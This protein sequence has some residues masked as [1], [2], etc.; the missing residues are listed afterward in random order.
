M[1]YGVWGL[2]SGE[3]GLGLGDRGTAGRR[4]GPG[5]AKFCVVYFSWDDCKR[6]CMTS[7]V[8]HEKKVYFPNRTHGYWGKEGLDGEKRGEILSKLTG[9]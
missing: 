7:T 9:Q 5:M 4:E 3:L 6:T 2:A 8:I 1:G